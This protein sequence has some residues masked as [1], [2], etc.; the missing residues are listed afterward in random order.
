MLF[1][2]KTIIHLTDVELRKIIDKL[3][4][5][6]ARNGPEFEEM[7]KQKQKG[8]ARFAFL[9]GGDN[10]LYYQYKV[11][12]EKTNLI[13]AILPIILKLWRTNEKLSRW[14]I[15]AILDSL[16]KVSLRVAASRGKPVSVVL[17]VKGHFWVCGQVEQAVYY[18]EGDL[19]NQFAEECQMNLDE[20][21]SVMDSLKESCTK[22]AISSCKSWIFEHF[23][24]FKHGDTIMR[25]LMKLVKN[26]QVSFLHKLHVLYLVNDL[27]HQC[28]RKQDENMLMLLRRYIVALYCVTFQQH[29]DDEQQ[30]SKLEKLVG[31]W[32]KQGYFDDSTLSKLRDVHLGLQ[33]YQLELANE[34]GTVVSDIIQRFRARYQQYELQH[35]E[36]ARHI[37]QQ[38]NSLESQQDLIAGGHYASQGSVPCSALPGQQ[39]PA[40]SSRRSRFDSPV[41]TSGIPGGQPSLPI[42]NLPAPHLPSSAGATGLLGHCPP[43]YFTQGAWQGS[44]S[45]ALVGAPQAVA[46]PMSSASFPVPFSA[47]SGNVQPF[48][49]PTSVSSMSRMPTILPNMPPGANVPPWNGPLPAMPL[50]APSDMAMQRWSGPDVTTVPQSRT[51][52]LHPPLIP[53]P[54]CPLRPFFDEQSLIPKVAYYDLPAGVMAPLVKL[55]DHE[56]KPLVPD[57][58][59]LPPPM[60]PSERLVLA[61]DAFFAPPNHENPRDSDGWERLGLYE[62]YNLKSQTCFGNNKTSDKSS[63]SESNASIR[64]DSPS[65]STSSNRSSSG[66]P[67]S[68][69]HSFSRSKSRSRSKSKSKSRSSSPVGNE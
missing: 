29:A 49:S 53:P 10:F 17:Y 37:Q 60:P 46:G 48:Y 1:R 26:L 25:F 13:K 8:N 45:P 63:S 68:H 22:E 36:F 24:S 47:S 33:S 12:E 28:F 30:R 20:L 62:Y 34:Y 66:S 67:R 23:L 69:S 6:V 61:V 39:V 14:S 3:A 44:S 59:R 40:A 11:N 7:T 57:D 16:I 51:A 65:S 5:F 21:M 43:G 64:S 50:S 35:Q 2:N 38:L 58:I 4:Q 56:Y 41:P 32:E 31:I 18:M 52:I 55:E 19:L 27:C 15:D 54:M 9:F 42:S